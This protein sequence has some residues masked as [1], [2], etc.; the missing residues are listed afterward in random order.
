MVIKKLHIKYITLKLTKYFSLN[1]LKKKIDISEVG[2]PK[3]GKLKALIVL[4]G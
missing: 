4:V 3:N 2:D 1:F